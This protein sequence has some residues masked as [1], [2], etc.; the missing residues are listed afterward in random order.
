MQEGFEGGEVPVQGFAEVW[1]G[2]AGERGIG[3]GVHEPAHKWRIQELL[4]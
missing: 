4:C 1:D 2:E 3:L